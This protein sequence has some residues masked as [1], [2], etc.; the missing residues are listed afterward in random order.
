MR[1]KFLNGNLDDFLSDARSLAQFLRDER[2]YY[3]EGLL[4]Y[5]E[6]FEVCF[7]KFFEKNS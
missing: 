2:A 7:I 3:P 6:L 5:I 4:T 1:D